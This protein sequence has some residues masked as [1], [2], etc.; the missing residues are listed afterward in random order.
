MICHIRYVIDVACVRV[1]LGR[2]TL[3]KIAITD[4]AYVDTKGPFW[5]EHWCNTMWPRGRVV[6][7][8]RKTGWI[9]NFIITPAN[10]DDFLRQLNSHLDSRLVM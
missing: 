5:N 4:I 2:F 10:R 7:I 8:R 3:R 9:R 1:V 6:R